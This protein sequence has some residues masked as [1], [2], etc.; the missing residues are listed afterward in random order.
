MT[1]A[2]SEQFDRACVHPGLSDRAG[3]ERTRLDDFVVTVAIGYQMMFV[4]HRLTPK[5]NFASVKKCQLPSKLFEL[6]T[7]TTLI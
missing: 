6:G 1:A 2:R 3:A 7:Q 5:K 4:S